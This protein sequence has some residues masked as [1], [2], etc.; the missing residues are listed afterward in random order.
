VVRLVRQ[1]EACGYGEPYVPIDVDVLFGNPTVA[2]RGPWGAADLLRVGPTTADLS[3]GLYEYHLDF[4]GNALAPGCDYERWDDR[5]VSG[6]RPTTYAHVVSDP[7]YPRGLALQYWFFYA[8]ND[9]NNKHE[10]D[11][12]LIQLV[13][14]A[15]GAAQ[16]LE[17]EPVSVGYSQHEGA[18]QADWGDE[19]LELVDG[20]HP[21][22]HA[23]A[24]SHANY[25]EE[26]LYLGRS[27]QQGV[28]CDDTSGP[29]DELRPVVRTIPSDPAAA[30]RDFPWI[31]YEGRWGELH[32]AFYNGPTGPNLK[33]QWTRPVAWAEED[34]HP[35]SYAIPAGGLLGTPATDFFCSSVRSG[36]DALRQL[37]QNPT[38]ILL[39]FSPSSRCHSSQSAGPPGRPRRR[40]E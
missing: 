17:N 37:I 25:F 32:E 40:S 12:E 4:P 9:F 18:E 34:W 20:T 27:A 16:A 28:G 15:E 29:T 30:R 5:L 8:F 39:G 35:R 10:G 7:A 31:S 6:S 19:K 33:A 13:F 14:D 11:W 1:Q 2:L 22:V 36:S 23:A 26:A 21:V 3:R 24:G 38:P